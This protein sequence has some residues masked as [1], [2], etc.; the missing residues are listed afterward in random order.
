MKLLPL[1]VLSYFPGSRAYHILPPP[2]DSD[3]ND[4]DDDDESN[5]DDDDD[6]ENND[7]NDDTRFISP[8]SMLPLPSTSYLMI[9]L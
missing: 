5:D 7:D 9:K 3:D 4:N 6:N 8:S 1:L 2:P